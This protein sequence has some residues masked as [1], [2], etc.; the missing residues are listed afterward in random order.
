MSEVAIVGAGM[1]RFGEL[2]KSSLRDLFVEA[3]SGAM[4]SAGVDTVVSTDPLSHPDLEP[5]VVLSPDR[6][7]R[8]PVR[9]R[10][11]QHNSSCVGFR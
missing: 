9:F 6:L 11:D 8:W 1:T 4:N 2:W 5:R 3:A 7:N 10:W